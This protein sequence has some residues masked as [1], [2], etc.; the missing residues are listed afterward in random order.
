MDCYEN[1]DYGFVVYLPAHWVEM[2]SDREALDSI[3]GELRA[4]NPNAADFL[5]SQ[6]EELTLIDYKFVGFDL[7]DEGIAKGYAPNVAL[8]RETLYKEITLDF[9]AEDSVATMEIIDQ[10]IK[11]VEHRRV[12]LPVGPAEELRY[13]MHMTPLG[14]EPVI[15]SILQ[16]LLVDGKNVYSFSMGA[17]SDQFGSYLP[18]FEQIAQRFTLN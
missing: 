15:V 3:L 2:P 14:K 12:S 11:P 10:V 7:I 6:F 5:E 13:Q 9:Y 17:V 4:E 18:D 8:H 16:Y 1:A